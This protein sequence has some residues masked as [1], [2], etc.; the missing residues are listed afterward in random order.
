MKHHKVAQL[1]ENAYSSSKE[2]FAQWIWENHVQFVARKAEELSKKFDANEDLAVAGAW[3]HDF[4]DAFAYRHSQEHEE[5][6][7]IEATKVLEASG[8]SSKEVQEILEVI[9]EPHSCRDGNVPQTKEGQILA[10][11]DALAH[12]ETDF[13]IQFTW[14]HLPKGKSY[15]EFIDWV[16]EKLDRDYTK[17]IFFEEIKDQT[18]D[19]YKILKE[20]FKKNDYINL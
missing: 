9:I 7:K 18:K 13:Y 20:V 16:N 11:A 12:L 4:G 2:D 15:K 14:M 17:K 6:S 3:L 19:R 5:V 1:A 10:T 8:Y